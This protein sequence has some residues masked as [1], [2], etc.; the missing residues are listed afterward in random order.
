MSLREYP[1]LKGESWGKW[2]YGDKISVFNY[3]TAPVR[4][5]LPY[6]IAIYTPL[7]KLVMI[8]RA[9]YFLPDKFWYDREGFELGV[10]MFK[11]C[12]CLLP[13]ILEYKDIF[14]SLV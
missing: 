12:T 6:D 8:Q 13:V 7:L 1:C 5:L 14:K 9:V 2:R 10:G 11:G 3:Y 4:Q